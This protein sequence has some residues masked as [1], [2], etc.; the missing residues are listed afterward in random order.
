[1]KRLIIVSCVTMLYWF[2]MEQSF[3]GKYRHYKGG[4]YE[5]I[6]IAKHS[7]SLEE[8]VVYKALYETADD[9]FGSLWVR[10]KEMFFEK[11]EVEGV[12]QPRFAR[13]NEY[14]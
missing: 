9:S 13:L 1:M 8:L 6:G 12:R 11:I 4:V 10:P 3:L 5:V 14:A 2:H 7:E